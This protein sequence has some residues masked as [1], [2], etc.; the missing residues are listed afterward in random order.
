MKDELKKI[1][2][3]GLNLFGHPQ[4]YNGIKLYPILIKDIKYVFITIV[5]V[6]LYWERSSCDRS[7]GLLLGQL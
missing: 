3:E 1:Y 7:H 6:Y 2:D 5:E 4:E